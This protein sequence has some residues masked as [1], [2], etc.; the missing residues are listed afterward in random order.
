MLPDLEQHVKDLLVFLQLMVLHRE[1]LQLIGLNLM[2]H[3]QP[4]SKADLHEEMLISLI[5]DHICHFLEL[6]KALL[7]FI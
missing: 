6:F 5:Q 7:G 1:R 2:Q 3:K 4:L